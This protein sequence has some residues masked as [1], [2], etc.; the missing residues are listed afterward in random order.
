EK[1]ERLAPPR[2]DRRLL[3]VEGE[4][5][6]CENLPCPLKGRLGVPT[7]QDD[8]VVGVVH[9]SGSELL[10]LPLFPPRLQEAVHIDV[11]QQWTD[12]ATLWGAVCAALAAA[13]P[14][15]PVGAALLHRRLQPHP[16]ESQHVTVHH[17]PRH[18][19]YQ[20]AV[21]NRV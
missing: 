18:T 15:L 21:R 2:S 5:D 7:T 10:P 9:H 12:H 4:S 19:E 17:S 6:L 11:R 14:L 3:L 13:H 1:V 20:L 8:E 16:D